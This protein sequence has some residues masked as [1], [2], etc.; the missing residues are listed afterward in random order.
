MMMRPTKPFSAVAAFLAALALA[1]SVHAQEERDTPSFRAN[2]GFS[3]GLGPAI[4]LP[5]DAGPVGGGL[6]LD[7]RYGIPAGPIIVAPGGR[8]AG[9]FISRRFVGTAM[10]TLR[11]TLPAGPLAPYLLGG[12]GGGGLSNP[13]E[14]GVALMGGGGLTIHFGSVLAVGVEIT[15]QTITN[16]ELRSVALGPSIS[17]GG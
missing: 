10:P 3:L 17:F 9:Y 4:L 5:T 15:Y 1:P 7:G 11:V 6:V 8:L 13:S 14:G 12:V 16:T 2:R